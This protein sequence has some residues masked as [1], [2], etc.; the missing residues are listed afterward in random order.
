[1][2]HTNLYWRKPYARIQEGMVADHSIVAFGKFPY[3]QA[4]Y[5]TAAGQRKTYYTKYS[6]ILGFDLYIVRIKFSWI[7]R[8]HKAP[9]DGR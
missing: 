4:V 1:M 7:G 6:Y 5:T 9:T 8:E 3:D 2:K